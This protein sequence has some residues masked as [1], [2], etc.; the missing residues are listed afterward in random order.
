MLYFE[1]LYHNFTAIQVILRCHFA[2][3]SKK[4]PSSTDSSDFIV[5]SNMHLDGASYDIENGCLTVQR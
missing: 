5:I 4:V 2:P 1:R 3:H